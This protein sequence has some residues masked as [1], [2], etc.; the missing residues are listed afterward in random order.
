M[1]NTQEQESEESQQ[2]QNNL[3]RDIYGVIGVC[4]VV[5][6]LVARVLMDQGLMVKGTDIQVEDECQFK[7]TLLDYNLPLY[8]GGHPKSFF[9]GLDYIITPP[10]LSKSTDLYRRLNKEASNGKFKLLSVDDIINVIKPKKPVLCITGTNGKTTT[11]SL[12]KHICISANLIPTEHGFQ[13]LQGN[14]EYIPP[15]QCRLKGD[16]SILE[17]G[18]FGNPGDLK[19]IME[20]C[21]P[22]CG[23][24]TNITPDHMKNDQNFLNYASIK[25]ELVDYLHDKMLIINGDDPT[26]MGLIREHNVSGNITTFGVNYKTDIVNKKTCLCGREIALEETISG[27]GY[28]KCSCGL[29]RPQPHYLATDI[30]DGG[31]KLHTPEEDLLVNPPLIG[32]HNIYNT[33]AAIAAAKEFFRI[34]LKDIISSL[35]SFKGVPGRLDHVGQFNGVDVIIDFAHN[36]G[37]VETVLR[38]LKKLYKTIAVVITVSSE[39]GEKGDM[40]I[41]KKSLELADFIIPA[42]FYARKAADKFVQYNLDEL[43]NINFKSQKIILTAEY[44][45]EFKNGTLGANSDQVI[46]GLIEAL[47]CDVSAVV[48]IGEAAFKYKEKIHNV[49]ENQESPN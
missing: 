45:Q 8:L 32:L 28:Y 42:S 36:P 24:I 15:L 31:F 18:T 49:I 22:S 21:Q 48:C 12:L 44:P 39:S 38:E 9:K 26:V 25:G 1:D 41:L 20:R 16:V 11:T 46:N 4:G 17:T 37:G 40:I 5:N 29:E 27:M 10:S 2:S 35:E 23:I 47:R 43:N 19:F 3:N 14:I 7:Y 13:D 33:L 6:N 34:P 30:M